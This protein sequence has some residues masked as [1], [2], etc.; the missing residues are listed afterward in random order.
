[1]LRIVSRVLAIAAI[2]VTT[3][4]SKIYAAEPSAKYALLVGINEVADPTVISLKNAQKDLTNLGNLLM[5]SGY[6]VD[7][8]LG[9]NATEAAIR[10]KLK[11]VS[12]KGSADGVVL[13]GLFGW[14]AEVPK[15][16]SVF[17]ASD[18]KVQRVRDSGGEQLF[19]TDGLPIFEFDLDSQISVSSVIDGFAICKAGNRVLITD[20]CRD[21]GPRSRAFGLDSSMSASSLPRQTAILNSCSMGEQT[22]ETDEL[23]QGV[24]VWALLRVLAEQKAKKASTMGIIGDRVHVE[25][26]DFSNQAVWQLKTESPIIPE[27]VR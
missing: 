14:G 21:E 19:K 27:W 11:G 18:A 16:G 7:L 2:V 25:T 23:Q 12:K 22:I 10:D 9:K 24:F 26:K 1:M 3:T 5:A 6:E 8:L 20:C 17:I 13:V 15:T 4:S